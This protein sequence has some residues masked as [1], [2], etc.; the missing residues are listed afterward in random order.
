MEVLGGF[1]VGFDNDPDDIFERQMDFIRE[2]AIPVAMVGYWRPSP[3]RNF[4]GGWS[5]KPAH[6][7]RDHT[8]SNTD[9]VL[10]FIR[11]WTPPAWL[12]VTNPSSEISTARASIMP[13]V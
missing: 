10:N 11:R 1:I 8:G 7:S 9:C 12:K 6:G 4:G 2:S 13:L 5:A 3:T